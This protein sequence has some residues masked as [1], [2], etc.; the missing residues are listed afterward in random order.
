[1][2][3]IYFDAHAD[4]NSP[5]TTLSGMYGGMDVALAAGLYND[6]NRL[7]TGLDPPLPPSY[8]VL[9]DVRD[10]DPREKE[11]IDRL[12]DRPWAVYAKS[13][14]AGPEAVLRYLSRHTHRIAIM[15][16]AAAKHRR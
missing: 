8:I 7:I 3:L 5:E 9:G 11:L 15:K 6:N 14:F 12:R 13:T 2:G 10:T 16:P 4:V 1:M